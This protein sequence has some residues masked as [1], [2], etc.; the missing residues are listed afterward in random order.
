[1]GVAELFQVGNGFECFMGVLL[2]MGTK[3]P[4]GRAGTSKTGRKESLVGLGQ[5]VL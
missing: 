3:K 5:G 2:L 4:A 1:M